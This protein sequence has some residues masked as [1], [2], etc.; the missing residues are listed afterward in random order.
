[1][2][3]RYH[4]KKQSDGGTGNQS[5]FDE[6][7]NHQEDTTDD[8]SM[9]LQDSIVDS[10][11]SESSDIVS[12]PSENDNSESAD[13]EQLGFTDDDTEFEFDQDV[14]EIETDA[15]VDD[16][17]E[18]TAE[19]FEFNKDLFQPLYDNATISLC[20]AF[21]A[22]LEFK[23]ACRLPFS[24]IHMLLQLLQLLCPPNNCLPRTVYA[25]KKLFCKAS[26]CNEIHSF[27]ADCNTE[28]QVNQK[29]CANTV[30][31]KREP[32]KLIHF[33]ISGAIKKV[34]L[35]KWNSDDN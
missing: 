34:L 15:L 16:C 9:H 13:G 23:R 6:T 17:D 35:S 2:L 33:D 25:F 8:S 29:F 26:L 27:C 20:G 3:I 21:C 28:L 5:P 19:G 31:R 10:R 14:E 1:M 7:G 24:T 11:D 30:C 32:S 22:I 12:V 18:A 4:A